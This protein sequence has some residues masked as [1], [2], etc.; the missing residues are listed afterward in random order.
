[1]R[2]ARIRVVGNGEI[3]RNAGS[4]GVASGLGQTRD[5]RKIVRH[6]AESAHGT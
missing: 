2:M 6:S 4:N 5:P 1:M 3:V